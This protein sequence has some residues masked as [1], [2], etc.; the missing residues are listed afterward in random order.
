MRGGGGHLRLFRRGV[1]DGG[2]RLVLKDPISKRFIRS[3]Y[4]MDREKIRTSF[5]RLVKASSAPGAA[6][7]TFQ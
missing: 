4:S 2:G 5:N 7:T 3:K 1:R 6:P